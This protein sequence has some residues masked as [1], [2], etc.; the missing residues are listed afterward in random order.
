MEYKTQMLRG[1]CTSP[2]ITVKNDAQQNNDTVFNRK[3]VN[4]E[5]LD[6]KLKSHSQ[7][8]WGKNTE[9]IIIKKL[10][11]QDNRRKEAKLIFKMYFVKHKDL[12]THL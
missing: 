11:F 4:I 7:F 6:G 5:K 8:Y 3:E 9:G 12:T 10:S 2:L 1:I